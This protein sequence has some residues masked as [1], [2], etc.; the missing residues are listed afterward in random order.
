MLIEL[1]LIK[2]QDLVSLLAGIFRPQVDQV[3]VKV[4]MNHD[5]MDSYVMCLANKK[6]ATRLSKDMADIS[7]Y[8]PE[9]KSTEKYSLPSNFVLMTEIG[10]VATT[11]LDTRVCALI[12]KIPDV[13]DSIHISDQYSGIKQ[14]EDS[15]PSKM[16]DTRKMLIFT[17]NL[18]FKNGILLYKKKKY[19]P[20]N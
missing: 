5:D 1:R 13:I 12:N 6:T 9:K 17:L 15:A 11:L 19:G 14:P 8:C 4:F 2:R 16:P 10:E 7:V 20:Q 18:T 3:H